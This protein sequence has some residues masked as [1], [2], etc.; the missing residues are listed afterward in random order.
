[1]DASEELAPE[2]GTAAACR[3]MGVARATLYRR[4]N[5]SQPNK[6]HCPKRR[7]RKAKRKDAVTV[8]NERLR[9]ENERLTQRLK[10]AETIID[11]QKKVSEILG[12][13]LPKT[14]GGND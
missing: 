5:P 14:N 2:V 9:R 6:G 3:A 13:T 1:M 12:V 10:Q 4:R 8:E 7:G 11:V